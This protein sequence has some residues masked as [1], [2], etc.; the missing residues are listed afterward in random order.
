MPTWELP[1]L[2]SISV[3]AHPQFPPLKA[4][5]IYAPTAALQP[6]C[7]PT[8]TAAPDGLPLLQ[9]KGTA[10]DETRI[11]AAIAEMNQMIQYLLQRNIN[12][13]GDLAA[14]QK[15]IEALNQP[16]ETQP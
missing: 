7:I 6:A 15:E 12:L 2:A 10:M 5:S 3:P 8:T 9:H 4:L 14:A 1:A 16:K 11:N 13:A